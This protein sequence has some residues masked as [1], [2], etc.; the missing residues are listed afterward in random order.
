[1]FC[2]MSPDNFRPAFLEMQ[3]A[4]L[5]GRESKQLVICE[6]F[7]HGTVRK[8][9]ISLDL[10]NAADP[11]Q[12]ADA[13]KLAAFQFYTYIQVRFLARTPQIVHADSPCFGEIM[14][15]SNRTTNYLPPR[16]SPR[17]T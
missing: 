14:H 4:H 2:T 1:M 16:P 3:C 6:A 9:A 17:P 10:C 12:K 5:L 13:H 8:E 15:P 11:L 7:V